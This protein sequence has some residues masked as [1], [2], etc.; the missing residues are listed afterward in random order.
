M[1]LSFLFS[2]LFLYEYPLVLAPLFIEKL[3]F[4]HSVSIFILKNDLTVVGF[5]SGL[6]ALW[7]FVWLFISI[8][9]S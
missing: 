5:V 7:S 1:C 4:S 8:I 2:F 3:C 9:R 6:P